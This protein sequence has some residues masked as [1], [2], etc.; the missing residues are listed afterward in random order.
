MGYEQTRF[1][2][3]KK[4]TKTTKKKRKNSDART[5]AGRERRLEDRAASF[6]THHLTF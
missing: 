3:K 6:G 2:N 4:L 1:E 5:E